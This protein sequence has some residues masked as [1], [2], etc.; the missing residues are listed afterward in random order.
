M[1]FFGTTVN[2]GGTWSTEENNYLK[3]EI[4]NIAVIQQLNN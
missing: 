2:C 4:E 3:K 1:T